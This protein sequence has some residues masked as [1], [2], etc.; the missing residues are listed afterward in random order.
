MRDYTKLFSRTNIWKRYY[1]KRSQ[2]LMDELSGRKGTLGLTDVQWVEHDR[3]MKERFPVLERI[4][5]FYEKVTNGI[6]RFVDKIKAPKY[7]I[8]NYFFSKTHILRTDLK[9]GKWHEPNTRFESAVFC[10]LKDF[11]DNE[12]YA[13]KF[14]K[15]NKGAEEV[16]SGYE[17][18][19]L[20]EDATE[21]YYTTKPRL[22]QRA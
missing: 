16:N 6:E 12:S 11:I 7:F 13:Y 8:S 18:Y 19:K 21:F 9:K 1:Q 3:L 10:M 17:V 20:C 15:E 4:N 5:N 2:V 22:N 14:Y